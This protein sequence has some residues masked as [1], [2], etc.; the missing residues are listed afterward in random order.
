MSPLGV[1]SGGRVGLGIGAGW[2][3]GVYGSSGIPMDPAGER[4]DRL[5]E[6]LA[7]I[8]GLFAPGPFSYEGKH[9]RITG[10]DG[11]PKPV[12]QPGPPVLLGGGG[13]RVLAPAG[14]RPHIVGGYPA[15]R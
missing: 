6:G 1:L 10:L 7:V 2:V 13:P 3:A 15:R 14:R 5:E 11:L 12:Q 9:Y 4:V 8:R